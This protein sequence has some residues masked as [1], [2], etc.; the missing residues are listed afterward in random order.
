[1]YDRLV[2]QHTIVLLSAHRKLSLR[3]CGNRVTHKQDL[4]HTSLRRARRGAPSG[5]KPGRRSVLGGEA[6]VA[7]ADEPVD[8]HQIRMA[9]VQLRRQQLLC[10]LEMWQRLAV[11]AL[12]REHDAHTRAV[13]DGMQMLW[14]ERGRVNRLG[15]TKG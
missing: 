1:M 12:L 8:G 10:A 6:L 7:L 14:A 15:I 2:L 5:V 4:E 9:R 3:T 13:G 11:L